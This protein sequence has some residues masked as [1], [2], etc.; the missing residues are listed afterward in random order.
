VTGSDITGSHMTG[1]CME[2]CSAHVRFFAAF[3]LTMA[4]VQ[5]PWLSELTEGHVTPLGF[6]WGT[7]APGAGDI[8]LYVEE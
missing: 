6:L 3:F 5:V 2:V 1:S 7:H 4:V 8:A